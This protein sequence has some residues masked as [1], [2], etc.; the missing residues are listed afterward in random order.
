MARPIFGIRTRCAAS[1]ANR[2]L[3]RLASSHHFAAIIMATMAAHV[4]RLLQ[5]AAIAAFGMRDSGQRMM[6][7]THAHPR[8]GR[9]LLRDSHGKPNSGLGDPPPVPH[10]HGRAGTFTYSMPITRAARSS[11]HP[12]APQVIPRHHNAGSGCVGRIPPLTACRAAAPGRQTEILCPPPPAPHPGRTRRSPRL[13]ECRAS[14]V[15]RERISPAPGRTPAR[16][17]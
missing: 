11:R 2:A 15:A 14:S 12:P 16:N 8:G 10:Q 17:R 9:F 3:K 4:V 7:A 13:G 1:G 5:L 6:A